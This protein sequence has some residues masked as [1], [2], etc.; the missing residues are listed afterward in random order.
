MPLRHF[1]HVMAALH[2]T[3]TADAA[4]TESAVLT[5]ENMPDI[6]QAEIIVGDM[7]AVKSKVNSPYGY[8]QKNKCLPEENGKALGI[9]VNGISEAS[10][11]RFADISQTAVY[12]ALRPDNMQPEFR[13]ILPPCTITNPVVWVRDG[14]R[15]WRAEL[16]TTEFAPATMYHITLNLQ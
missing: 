8:I 1:R 4:L 14:D 2:I 15:R 9:G 12:K 13:F 7:Y 3:V 5:M 16:G 10:L 11:V 6:D